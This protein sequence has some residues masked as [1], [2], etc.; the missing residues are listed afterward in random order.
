M[1]PSDRPADQPLND[2]MA[3]VVLAFRGYN[4]TNLG[5]TRQLMSVPAYSEILREELSRY[6]RICSEYSPHQVDLAEV[7]ENG[8][9]PS[10]A[11]Y[12][13]SVALVVAVEM[14]QLR[15][16]REIH[17][18]DYA[19]AKMA[20]GYSLGEM[21]AVCCCGLFDPHE[22][23][24]VPL[25]MAADCADL[26]RDAEMGILFSREGMLAESEVRRMCLEITQ[27]GHGTVGISSVLSPNSY[28]LIGQG[29]SVDRLKAKLP[30]VFPGAH[31]RIN[32]HR[33]PPLHTPIVRQRHIPDR[34]AVLIE[35]LKL[36]AMPARPPV[37]SLV[38]GKRSYEPH[39]ARELLRQWI[40][41]PQRLWDGVCETL[42]SGAK[43]VLHIGPDPN[44]IP[45]T[46][47]RLAENVR[48]QAN[49]TSMGSYRMKAL[50]GMMQRPW[51]AS[52][53]PAR[54]ALLRAPFVQHVILEDWLLANAPAQS[55]IEP[56]TISAA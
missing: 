6:S 20:F 7:V 53:L 27:E 14:A 15:L 50:S 5:R 17:G 45:A 51:L 52:L 16:L 46:F 41:H 42:A 44:L 4:V 13:E 23:V 47:N 22:L 35:R 48:Q 29:Y 1:P 34:A 8:V 11:Q 26:A 40:D 19:L 43:T 21:V 36:G 28:L 9:E 55:A 18:T 49:G 33:W 38:T 2:R 10:L 12:A 30:D 32:D 3:D 31:L 56:A 54:A 25:A 37:V 39:T 24:R